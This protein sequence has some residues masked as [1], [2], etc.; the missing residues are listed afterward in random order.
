MHT[1]PL[2]QS[3][4]SLPENNGALVNAPNTIEK[5]PSPGVP[6]SDTEPLSVQALEQ[7]MMASAP[8]TNGADMFQYV[9]QPQL[10]ADVASSSQTF[11]YGSA[12][13]AVSAVGIGRGTTR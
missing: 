7:M 11:S 6:Q 13:D 5:V 12:G 3:C 1:L 10:C 4:L 8:L 2:P 9:E